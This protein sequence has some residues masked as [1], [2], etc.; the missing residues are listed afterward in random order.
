MLLVESFAG[1]IKGQARWNC[2]CD[3]GRRKVISGGA[4]GKGQTACGCR[5]WKHLPGENRRR[6]KHGMTRTS[7]YG[8]WQNMKARCLSPSAP[9]YA[10]YGGRGI[11]VCPQWLT[12][13]GFMADMGSGWSEGLSIERKD[14]NGHYEPGNCRWATQTE[15]CQNTRRTVWLNTPRG[16]LTIK[17]AAREFGLTEYCLRNRLSTLRW[18]VERAVTTPM[19]P[20]KRRRA[21]E[22]G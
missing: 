18:D 12:F 15:Q 10:D 6:S 22:R 21:G 20:N 11:I 16:R 5:M 14:P 19:A 17:E 7:A 8:S 3:C 4:L 2:L 9:N 1:I 13:E